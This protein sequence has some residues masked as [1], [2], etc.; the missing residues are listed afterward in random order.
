VQT[1]KGGPG[2]CGPEKMR[3]CEDGA[4]VAS[5]NNLRWNYGPA[6]PERWGGN[7]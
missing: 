7:G 5:P 4:E 1:H 2:V 3:F 6:H